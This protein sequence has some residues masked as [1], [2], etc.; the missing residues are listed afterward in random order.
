MLT[1]TNSSNSG[2]GV[3]KR[4]IKREIVIG[5]NAIK[6]V[7]LAIFAILALVYLTQSTEGA[8]RSIRVRDISDK[9]AELELK[10]ERFEV[11]K[12]RLRSLQQIDQ[13]IQKPAMEPISKVEHVDGN[14]PALAVR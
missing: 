11:E 3:K 1:M 7:T 8:N 14:N 10:E 12:V 2:L 5:P 13:N 9:K 4:A 6:F